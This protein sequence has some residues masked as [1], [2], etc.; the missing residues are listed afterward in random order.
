MDDSSE[1]SQEVVSEELQAGYR[2]GDEVIR[3]AMVRVALK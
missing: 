1:G 3:H 2:L